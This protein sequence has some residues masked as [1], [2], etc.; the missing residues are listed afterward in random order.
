MNDSSFYGNLE[1][2]LNCFYKN[3]KKQVWIAWAHLSVYGH[4]HDEVINSQPYY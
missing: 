4:V 1:F 2:T 3:N